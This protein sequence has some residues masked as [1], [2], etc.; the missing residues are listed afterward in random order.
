MKFITYLVNDIPKGAL[1]SPDARKALPLEAIY[2]HLNLSLA[3]SLLALIESGISLDAS[4][5]QPLFESE[6]AVPVQDLKLL[7]PIPAPP[8]N[9]FCLGK[10]YADHALEIKNIPSL[11]DVPEYPIYFTKASTSVTGP[12]DEVSSHQ[13]I[14]KQVDYEVELALVIGK[15]GKDIKKEDAYQYI[16]GY[17]VANDIT[18]RDLQRE[19][20]QWFKGK[21]LDTFC[22]MGP[23]LTT[24]EEL[25]HPLQLD[26]LCK[27]NGETRQ[28]SNTSLLIFDIPTIISDLSRG[29]TLLPGDIILTGT[30]GGVGF[31]MDPPRFLKSGDMVESVISELGSLKNIIA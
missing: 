7:S 1:L 16:F 5:L 19:H 9:V 28:S 24:K 3:D 2:R 6:D 25:T 4:S 13:A 31:A 8:R 27:V 20:S 14:T 10:N 12:Y 22:P 23:V 21:S 30:P 18:A 11:K 17:M 15:K 29:L 26:I